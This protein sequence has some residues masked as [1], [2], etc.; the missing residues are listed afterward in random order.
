L[1]LILIFPETTGWFCSFFQHINIF[2]KSKSCG[3][4]TT[5]LDSSSNNSSPISLASSLAPASDIAAITSSGVMISDFGKWRKLTRV[6]HDISK[7]R[8]ARRLKLFH[9][10]HTKNTRR[11]YFHIGKFFQQLFYLY[12]DIAAHT[13]S[14]LPKQQVSA[15]LYN[16]MKICRWE[17]TQKY[18][19]RVY[20][21][22]FSTIHECLMN[23][24][25]SDGFQR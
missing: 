20:L 22:L 17:I 9:Y 8:F 19:T 23:G 14:L 24:N 10:V 18:H 2:L 6:V 11:Q 12:R 1:D 21:H 25:K 7:D 3:S 4:T 16:I 13:S 15:N 5:T